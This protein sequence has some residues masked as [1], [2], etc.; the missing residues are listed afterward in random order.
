MIDN[1]KYNIYLEV[2][3][4]LLLEDARYFVIDYLSS[5]R[6]CGPDDITNKELE[7]YDFEKMVLQF[8]DR[9]RPDVAPNDIWD[10]IIVDYMEE[11]YE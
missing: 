5:T 8:E 1:K 11:D 2:K 6:D 3:H 7:K 10:D 4:Q 9:E